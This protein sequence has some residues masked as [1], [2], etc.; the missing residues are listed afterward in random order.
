MQL[1][2]IK[3]NNIRSYVNEKVSFPVGSTLLAGDI[4]AG[5]TTVLL[6]LDFALFGIRRGELSGND[7]LRHGSGNGFVE[8]EFDV[9]GKNVVIKRTLKREKNNTVVQDSGYV[10]VNGVG[11]FKS[12]TELRANVLDMLGYPQEFITKN[13]ILFRY[14]IYTPQDQMKRI[15]FN[16]EERLDTIRKIFGI[17]KYGRIRENSKII[18][19]EMR[20]MKRVL[21]SRAADLEERVAELAEKKQRREC[22]MSDLEE[23]RSHVADIN[24]EMRRIKT[25]LEEINKKSAEMDN[26]SGKIT[27]NNSEI[28]M[29]N[30]R[31]K[32]ISLDISELETKLLEYSASLGAEVEQPTT[33]TTTEIKNRLGKLEGEEREMISEE[34]TLTHDIRKLQD[35]LDDG[36]CSFCEQPV[37]NKS[38]FKKRIEEKTIL[39][40]RLSNDILRIESEIK[41]LERIYDELVDY[42]NKMQTRVLI[43]RNHQYAIESFKKLEEERTGLVLDIKQLEA[44]MEELE[45]RLVGF[46]DIET[47]KIAIELR[48]D[49]TNKRKISAE[50]ELSRIEQQIRN[51]DELIS[52]LEK[53]IEDKKECKHRILKLAKF[54]NWIDDSFV[55]L[56][57]V[58]ERHVLAT[59]QKEFNE[60]FQNWFS[61][62][63]SDEL[64][65][66][67]IDEQF[68]PLIQQNNY[69]TSY[70]NLS[71][72]EKTAVAL[73]YRLSLNK[74]INMIM[75]KIKTSDIIILDE[76]TDGFSTDQ[77]DRVR[78]VLNELNLKQMIIVSHEPKID[79]FVDN[80]IRFYKEHHVT[81]VEQ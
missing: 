51:I 42:N 76:P 13:P 61:L 71:G 45:K 64:L 69:D 6:A 32:K 17:D 80:V 3:L 30:D 10:E 60:Y 5:K 47:E 8:L 25:E 55:M 58:M 52:D 75:E 22:S 1:K 49:D 73:A 50:K 28:R 44:S 11:S 81:R 31:I 34:S 16:D 27:V 65:S 14:T 20:T 57:D 78:D 37:S 53:E 24:K 26:L 12:P 62:L 2:S 66:V 41:N 15:F 33:M 79:T 74:V 7:L 70:E 39:K 18:L 35:I 68:T 21:E 59:I 9:D 63:I 38:D 54:V 46:V 4:G 23:I 19:T 67:K 48:L 77:L 72:G 40:N 43:E 29:K 56:M 36:V